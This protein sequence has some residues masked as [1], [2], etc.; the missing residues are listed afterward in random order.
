MGLLGCRGE[1]L[2]TQELDRLFDV[3]IGLGQRLLAVHHAGAGLVSELLHRLCCD[4]HLSLPLSKRGQARIAPGPTEN[5][6]GRAS[7][8]LR[9]HL[10]GCFL[11]GLCLLGR[12][13]V[14][15]GTRLGRLLRLRLLGSNLV[16][17]LYRSIFLGRLASTSSPQGLLLSHPPPPELPQLPLQSLQRRRM[18]NPLPRPRSPQQPQFIVV[19]DETLVGEIEA[20]EDVVGDPRSEESDGADGIVVSGDRKIDLF[21]VA[22][23]VDHGDHRDAEPIGLF[24]GDVLVDRVDDEEGVR[25]ILHV[26]DPTEGPVHLAAL[27]LESN[28]LLLGQVRVLVREV[29]SISLNRSMDLRMVR[30]LVIVPPSQRWFM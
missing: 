21:R 7:G 2:G 20:L 10:F 15:I 28:P 19:T 14:G 1:T 24:D 3:A 5:Q 17:F 13:V 30:K 8:L 18:Q 11:F 25:Q 9:G 26:L 16:G 22:V 29:A 4:C 12:G 27:T 23:G 6:I